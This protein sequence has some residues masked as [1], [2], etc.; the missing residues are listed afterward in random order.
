MYLFI[1]LIP[2]K[3]KQINTDIQKSWNLNVTTIST[4]HSTEEKQ[5]RQRWHTRHVSTEEETATFLEFVHKT[6]INVT[7]DGKQ[8]QNATV[9]PEL[10]PFLRTLLLRR[11]NDI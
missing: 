2:V 5:T 3:W 6:N 11:Y 1:F 10:P 4:F 8:Q 7:L 9:Y